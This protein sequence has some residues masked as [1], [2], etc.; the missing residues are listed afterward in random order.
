MSKFDTIYENVLLSLRESIG[1]KYNLQNDLSLLVSALM[2][3]SNKYLK[4]HKGST[5]DE[6]LKTIV[7]HIMEQQGPVY[8]IPLDL[9]DGSIPPIVLKVTDVN[10]N[11]TNDDDP[12]FT[13][14]IDLLTPI[15]G[16]D[17]K[18]TYQDTDPETIFNNVISKLDSIVTA[19]QEKAKAEEID[20]AVQP[21]P[22]TTGPTA[23]PP[24]ETS[25]LPGA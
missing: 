9:G 23:Q 25:A 2:H 21:L 7:A 5:P 1:E 16:V 6:T 15:E 20:K 4:T 19:N 11:R 13:I 14:K 10:A 12:N 8:S 3:A 17:V 18:Q 22:T 24:G